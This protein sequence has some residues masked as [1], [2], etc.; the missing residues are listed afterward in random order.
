M[1]EQKQTPK[2][3]NEHIEI[4]L[5]KDVT[6]KKVT[7]GFERYRFLHQALPEIDFSEISLST[8]FLGKRMKAPLLISSM[9]GGTKETGE[10]NKRLAVA[11]QQ[12][13]WAVGLGSGRAAIEYPE[14]AETFQVRSVA[15][16]IPLL[17]NLGAVQLNY[18]VSVDDC[19]R[20]VEIV[21]ADALILHLNPMQEVFQPEGNTRFRGLLSKIEKVCRA[22]EVPVGIKEVG[23][24]IDGDLAVKLYNAGAAFIDVAGAGG[25]SW[26]Q[27][28]KYRSKKPL[29]KEAA[30]SFLDWGIPTA[31]CLIG[32]RKKVPQGFLI[33]SGGLSSGVDA[34]K[35][36]ALGADLAGFGRSLLPA[37]ARKSADAMV[38]RLEKIEL[39]LKLAMFGIGVADVTELK[40][41]N[42]L[43]AARD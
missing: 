19:R 31:D 23:S 13:G 12:R 15:P 16:D 7:S 14:V 20:L 17:A 1:L 37:A 5:N 9:T 43:T 21:E 34:A 38:A 3:K 26:I 35:A 39:E 11:A 32:I 6:G 22:L 36:I 24:G 8:R 42:R 29:L 41:T 4:A 25:T 2:R 27:V 28:E 18:G 10:I 40:K 30:E 33:A